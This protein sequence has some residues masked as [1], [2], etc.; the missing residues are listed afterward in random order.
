MS[1][2]I[3]PLVVPDGLLL[4]N[5]SIL[6]DCL[7]ASE[8]VINSWDIRRFSGAWEQDWLESKDTL[9]RRKGRGK[10]F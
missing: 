6:Q 2:C 1:V 5:M 8:P 4:T 7:T 3:L 10:N 9:E